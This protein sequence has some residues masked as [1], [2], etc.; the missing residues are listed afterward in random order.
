MLL[1]IHSATNSKNIYSTK[2]V[3][4]RVVG[5]Y[6]LLYWAQPLREAE[7]WEFDCTY[8]QRHG[9]EGGKAQVGKPELARR[10]PGLRQGC[11]WDSQT[12]G[13]TGNVGSHRKRAENGVRDQRLHLTRGGGAPTFLTG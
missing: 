4:C 2:G 7:L 3:V 8:P 11:V 12:L 1:G 13:H 5:L 6:P 9:S 10:S